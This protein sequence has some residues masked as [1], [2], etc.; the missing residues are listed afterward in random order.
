MSATKLQSAQE[1]FEQAIALESSKKYSEILPLLNNV[2][3]DG[4]LNPDQLAEAYL[5]RARCHCEA[6]AT[7]EAEKDLELAEQGAPD[8]AKYHLTRAMLLAKL[9]RT[10]ESKAEMAKAVKIDPKLKQS[11]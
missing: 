7:S 5:L 8:P 9:N 10:A 3:Q 11:K 1:V 4:G 6:G 2:L